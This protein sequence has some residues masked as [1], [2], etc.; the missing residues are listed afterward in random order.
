[1]S[2][3]R[4][5]GW[6]A[7][8]LL[9]PLVAVALALP[10]LIDLEA[11][12]PALI[13]AV[14]EAT[15]R[16]LVIDGPIRLRMLPEPRL[17]AQQVHFANVAGA[18]G[19]QMVDVRWIGATPSWSALLRGR[20]E[21]GRIILFRPVINLETDADG[22]PNWEFKPGA[23][24]N[25]PDGAP[26]E[27]L[28][29]AI[30]ELRIREGT[31]SYTNP[32]TKQTI[33]AE[34][35]DATANVSSLQGPLSIS[36]K[37]TVNGVPL[38]L[39]LAMSEHKAQGHDLSFS[40]QVLSGRLEFKGHVS[41]L[42]ASAELKGHLAVTTGTLT[43]FVGALVRAG[44]QG[45][46]QFDPSVI[47]KF[48][49]D[50]GVEYTPTR[51][52]ITDFKMAMGEETVTGTL[53][54]EQNATPSLKGQ[55]ALPKVDLEKW[56]TLL[57]KP[58]AF[59]PAQP[60]AKAAAEPAA[61]ATAGP[62]AKAP[63]EPA[64]KATAGPAAKAPAEP[65]AKAPAEPVAKAPAEPAAKSP[66]EPAAKAPVGPVAKA[67]VGPVAKAPATPPA[68]APAAKPASLSPF[69]AALDVSL[70]LD[71]AELVYRK[72]M[73]RNL[74]AALEVHKGVITVPQFKALLPGDMAVQATAVAASQADAKGELSVT[75]PRL[76]ETL[77][78]LGIDVSGVPQDRLQTLD[79][80]GKLAATDKGV[81]IVDMTTA[82]DGQRATGTG[83]M[84]FGPPLAAT[85]T[86][87]IDQFDLDA[88]LPAASAAPAAA[89]SPAPPAAP[90]PAAAAVPAPADPLPVFGLKAKVAKLVFRKQTL[91]GVEADASVQ[92]NVLKINALKVADLLGGKM[93]AKG[94]VT[95]F[96]TVPRVDL[97]F[98][99]TLPDADK[100]TDY[101]GLPKFINGKIGAASASG[102]VAGGL[103]A[104][105][106]RNVSV[107]MLGSTARISGSLKPGK[108]LHY[109][110]PGFSLQTQDVGRLLAATTGRPAAPVGALSATGALKGDG[111]RVAFDGNLTAF[112]TALNGHVDS[113]LTERPAIT[114]NLRVPGTLS[115]D[116][117]L[118]VAPG[119][120]AAPGANAAPAPGPARAATGKPIDLSAFRAFDA[121]MTL[122]TSATT[123][124]SLKINYADMQAKL[125]NGVLTIEKLTGQFYG[126]A[127]D[128]SGTV[129]AT[130]AA[131]AVDLRGSL[132]GIY[133][134]E[135]LR[136]TAGTNSFGND[137]LTVAVEGKI[138]VMDISVRGG[139]RTTQEIRDS[140]AGRGQVGGTIYP[141]VI[142]GSLG[143]A[144]FA[145]GVGSIFSTEMGFGSAMLSAFINQ[146][147]NIAG[148]ATL[149][150]GTVSLS[151]H[152]LQG[153]NAVATINSRTSLAAATTDTTIA[154]DTGRRGPADYVVTV[155][156]PVSSPTMTT[157]GGN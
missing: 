150:G 156:G 14:K 49:F 66:A 131:L 138:N 60:V 10:W 153:Q 8:A 147:S 54:F 7:A 52:A 126:G 152:T 133:F 111:Q 144:S 38:S 57:G 13:Q 83:S 17:S 21:V 120:A 130:K 90:T 121:T 44:G 42:D 97:T 16:E 35:V 122:E 22:V 96:G 149:A 29:L 141:T 45:A 41:A 26:A 119:P 76:R 139:G 100:V 61:K 142:K 55:L 95:D 106:L 154:L 102:G 20:A 11:Y 39:E 108:D 59:L 71:I 6:A 62:V 77:A 151:N 32:R 75:G 9:G 87:Q 37:A 64:A 140:L 46:P 103:D 2:V 31:I 125:R 145:T 86:V 5:I 128:F 12:K 78:W 40:V 116:D 94:T 28:H 80:K 105:T 43:E 34:Q 27:G 127:V 117:W 47:G 68:P 19:A 123:I 112:G 155:K 67:P 84:I 135:M 107:T 51:I 82:L 99:A 113:T 136:G 70:A 132:Q 4:R 157:K 124:A 58:G 129:D 63:A 89:P 25:Q 143:L 118:G 73:V 109:D 74:T 115:L 30:G 48:T 104:V 33:K 53:A 23:G 72:G 24:A 81:Q 92:G 3:R 69:P 137:Q 91:G 36:G 148:E 50:G 85:A 134:G 79:L 88:Y 56:L 146:Q 110:F 114:V 93:D 18:V 101:A 98:N 1:M 15:G 65:V